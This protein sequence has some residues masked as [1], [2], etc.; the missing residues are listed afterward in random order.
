M[1]GSTKSIR[2]IRIS[3]AKKRKKRDP[4][5]EGGKAHHLRGFG[6]GNVRKPHL[7]SR[8]LGGRQQPEIHIAIDLQRSAGLGLDPFPQAP[9]CTSS[10]R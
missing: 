5:V 3:P 10:N 9:S 7:A 1:T 6:A 2:S 8:Q 4:N